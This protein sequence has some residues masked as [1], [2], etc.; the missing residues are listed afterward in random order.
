MSE[1][2]DNVVL[3]DDWLLFPD[4]MMRENSTIKGAVT[5]KPANEFEKR[6]LQKLFWEKKLELSI[7]EFDDKKAMLL[8][9]VKQRLK[10]NGN[11]G[12]CPMETTEAV[13]LLNTL[14]SKVQHCQ[15]MLAEAERNLEEATPLQLT[16]AKDI[17]EQNRA[18][19]GDFVSAVESIE[20]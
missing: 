2:N 3:V 13:A 11:P 20:I 17:A 6:R 4:G 5:K 15:D 16:K 18:R 7:A 10:Q 1:V 9:D 14:K 8:G 12:G 19:L